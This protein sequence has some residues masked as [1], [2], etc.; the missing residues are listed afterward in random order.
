MVNTLTPGQAA[1]EARLASR[2]ALL[3]H[4]YGIGQVNKHWAKLDEHEQ[5]HEEA[6]AQAA[7]DA[8]LAG[9][10]VS[11]ESIREALAAQEPRLVS[12]GQQLAYD[13]DR[14][15]EEINA[16]DDGERDTARRMDAL[17]EAARLEAGL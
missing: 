7:I 2:A 5:V 11:A 17:D 16:E 9:D 3:G 1:Y 10:S 12:S 14:E 13:E 6:G 4:A 15:A 8:F